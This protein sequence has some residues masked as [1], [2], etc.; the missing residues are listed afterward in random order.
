MRNVVGTLYASKD[1]ISTEIN[2]K[3]GA[4]HELKRDLLGKSS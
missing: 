4:T 1:I 2:E 3:H